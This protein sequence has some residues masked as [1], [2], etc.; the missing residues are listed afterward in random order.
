VESLACQEVDQMKRRWNYFGF[1]IR[2]WPLAVKKI[3]AIPVTRV[4]VQTESVW[5]F[6]VVKIQ[7]L[8]G[9]FDQ[10]H[11]NHP[12][13]QSI[14]EEYKPKIKIFLEW[15]QEQTPS[16]QSF[17]PNIDLIT[18][19]KPNSQ[20]Q[21]WTLDAKSFEIS[22]VQFPWDLPIS[23]RTLS[24]QILEKREKGEWLHQSTDLYFFLHPGSSR[25]VTPE[26]ITLFYKIKAQNK[27]ILIFSHLSKPY[28]FNRNPFEDQLIAMLPLLPGNMEGARFV[29]NLTQICKVIF[30]FHSFANLLLDYF[31]AFQGTT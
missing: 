5:Q 4:F 14:H 29:K 22:M 18:D 9:K 17:K 7:L 20:A 28:R 25:Q 12:S 24:A 19:I 8:L 27:R 3:R 30:E 26:Q 16:V 23:L 10:A 2:L 6:L 15:I 13:S 31:V 1:L 11:M 21:Y